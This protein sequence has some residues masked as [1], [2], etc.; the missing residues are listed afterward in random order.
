M[1]RKEH[2]LRALGNRVLKIYGPKWEEVMGGW[3]NYIM[4][5]FITCTLTKY[6]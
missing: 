4:S 3:R 2:R 1:V 6:Y 5:S